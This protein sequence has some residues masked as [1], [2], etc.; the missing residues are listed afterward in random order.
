M[1]APLLPRYSLQTPWHI[2][3]LVQFIR[4][5]L[6]V[7][8]RLLLHNR[9]HWI[10][11]LAPFLRYYNLLAFLLG[12]SSY[13]SETVAPRSVLQPKCLYIVYTLI[14]LCVTCFAGL[15]I[16][17]I[18]LLCEPWIVRIIGC[19]D[20]ITLSFIMLTNFLYPHIR[21]STLILDT[22]INFLPPLHLSNS[23]IQF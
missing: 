10:K 17:A 11:P 20:W 6:S 5:V 19:R 13:I 9:K 21:L 16:L 12:S 23:S 18:I 2:V 1:I 14:Q 7:I 8:F 22:V 3:F 4:K 15:I